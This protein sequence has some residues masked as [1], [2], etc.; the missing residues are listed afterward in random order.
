MKQTSCTLPERTL[1]GIKTR[2]RP[3]YELSSATSNILKTLKTYFGTNVANTIPNRLT[4][5][6]TYCVYTEYESNEQGEYTYFVGEEVSSED[7]LIPSSLSK[8][9]IPASSYAKFECGPGKMPDI[10]RAAWL[11]I[12]QLPAKDLGGKRTYKADFE[13]Y[14]ERAQDP[15]HTTFDLYVGLET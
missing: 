9:I 10:C 15:T 3:T 11:K 2:T 14:D 12:W 6:A 1:I 13:V 4:P 8:L 5:S 7:C